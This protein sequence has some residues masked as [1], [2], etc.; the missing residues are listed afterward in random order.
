MAA[1]WQAN[2]PPWLKD[3][4]EGR[5]PTNVLDWLQPKKSALIRDPLPWEMHA[6]TDGDPTVHVWRLVCEDGR[7]LFQPT[8]DAIPPEKDWGYEK[9]DRL[10]AL[11][12]EREFTLLSKAEPA[13]G[14]R[15]P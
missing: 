13:P 3:W 2:T 7:E 8:D 15:R 11:F 12:P 9:L 5:H 4:M 6:K 14:P 1:F 10:L